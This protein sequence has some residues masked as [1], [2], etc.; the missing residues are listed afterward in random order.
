MPAYDYRC[1]TCHHLWS[2]SRPI[3]ERR[4]PLS[5]PICGAPGRLV[6]HSAPHLAWY[7]DAPRPLFHEPKE[8]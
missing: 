8:Y 1:E 5:C 6:I 2:V 4:D 3:A 7:P